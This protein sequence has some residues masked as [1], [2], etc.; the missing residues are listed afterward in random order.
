MTLQ[1][2]KKHFEYRVN[3]TKHS[4]KKARLIQKL[5]LTEWVIDIEDDLKEIFGVED[6]VKYL[7]ERLE[8]YFR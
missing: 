5:K 2:Y 7:E 4:K 6:C 1:D 3:L 8:A